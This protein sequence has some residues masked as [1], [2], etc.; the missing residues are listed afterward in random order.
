MQI[1]VKYAYIYDVI[2]CFFN[3]SWIDDQGSGVQ[4]PSVN[5]SIEIL[6]EFK[7]DNS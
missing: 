2:S 5:F 1:L 4:L 3:P 6:N 7:E